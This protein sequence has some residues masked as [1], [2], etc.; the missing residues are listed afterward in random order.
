MLILCYH[1]VTPS[2]ADP[3]GLCVTPEHFS[4]QM[5]VLRRDAD[6]MP[7]VDLAAA[8]ATGDGPARGVAV[9]FDDGY[10]DNLAATPALATSAIA[11][12]VFV[13]T[14]YVAS[15]REFWWDIV[16]DVFLARET[17]PASLLL[18]L[19]GVSHTWSL[20]PDERLDRG[21]AERVRHWRAWD[22]APTA[23]HAAYLD[24]WNRL[25]PLGEASRQDA[26]ARLVAWADTCGLARN[27][28]H[29]GRAPSRAMNPTELRTIAG[30]GVVT[31]GAHTVTHPLLAS[32]PAAEQ[33][34]EIAA[35]RAAVEAIVNRPVTTFAYPY[36]DHS[37]Q[38]R[39]A[40]RAAGI[41]V[42]CVGGTTAVTSTSDPLCLPR[43]GVED[44]D[45]A[46]FSRRL[47]SWWRR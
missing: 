8:A 21:A 47:D 38:T 22:A 30:S 44:W 26:V 1:R 10:V 2:L 19:D 34:H 11:A 40:A 13:A 45:A 46:V 4:Q 28:D 16:Q 23:R 37:A 3:W 6:P 36:G 5:A 43:C 24:V 35:S 18:D 9:T 39:T 41:T 7:L 12:T 33:A 17:L 20:R 32:L 25:R 31:L 15:G 42:A 29:V 14:D 27:D